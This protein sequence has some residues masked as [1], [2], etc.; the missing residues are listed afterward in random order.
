M[1]QKLFTIQ[2][3]EELLNG[4]GWPE[5]EVPIR[6][7]EILV[8]ELVRLDR[9]SEAEA[10]SFLGLDR[11]QLLDLMRKLRV[12]AIQMTPRELKREV[13]GASAKSR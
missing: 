7:K 11:W 13:L 10:A 12:P 5:T 4:F 6:V 3:P 8:M 2:L 9:L 1:A